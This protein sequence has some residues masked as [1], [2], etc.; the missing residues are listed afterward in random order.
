MNFVFMT[1]LL[2]VLVRMADGTCGGL[3]GLREALG[4]WESLRGAGLPIA[5]G[6]D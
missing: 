3:V 1:V 2:S 5:D 4:T 6:F